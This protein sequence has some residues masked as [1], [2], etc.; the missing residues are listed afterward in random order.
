MSF[1]TVSFI[2]RVTEQQEAMNLNVEHP[3][4]SAV[5]EQL[6]SVCCETPVT[7]L[8]RYIVIIV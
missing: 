2:S 5:K 6:C 8:I 3:Q 1:Y 7:N 4:K